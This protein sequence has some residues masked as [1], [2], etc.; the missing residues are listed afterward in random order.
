M[1]IFWIH[2]GK[3]NILLKGILLVSFFNVT[4]EKIKSTRV[5]CAELFANI[6]DFLQRKILLHDITMLRE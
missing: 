3:L 1:I 5:C 2:C 6:S 4:T